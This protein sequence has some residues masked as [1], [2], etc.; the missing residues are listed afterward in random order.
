[1]CSSDLSLKKLRLDKND[2]D[3][4]FNSLE[5]KKAAKKKELLE[6]YNMRWAKEYFAG[7][8]MECIL[9]M[10]KKEVYRGS[11]YTLSSFESNW[12]RS[13]ERRVGKEGRLWRWLCQ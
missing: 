1:M 4:I 3:E 10:A 9:E 2:L 13:E 6:G 12:N 11:S 7:I 8:P 5:E